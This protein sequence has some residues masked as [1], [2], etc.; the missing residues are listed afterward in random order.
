MGINI[1]QH[2]FFQTSSFIQRYR[3]VRT[4]Y[5]CVGE[6]NSELSFEANMIITNG[7]FLYVCGFGVYAH[8]S[9]YV[10]IYVIFSFNDLRIN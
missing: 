10:H 6:N 4:K 7:K 8:S 5:P 3:K 9:V 1:L 2:I